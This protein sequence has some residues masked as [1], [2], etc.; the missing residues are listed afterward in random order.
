M[1]GH[2]ASE[3][4]STN[5][6]VAPDV[7]HDFNTYLSAGIVHSDVNM[8]DWWSDNKQNYL[9]TALVDQHI[10]SIPMTSVQSERLLFLRSI[11]DCCGVEQKTAE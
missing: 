2:K 5:S 1:E 10:L 3:A 11:C 6:S 4:W 8:T 9:A 7:H